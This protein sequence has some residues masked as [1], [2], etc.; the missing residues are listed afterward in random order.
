ML[1][2]PLQPS[3]SRQVRNDLVR[4]QN[5]IANSLVGRNVGLLVSA[6]RIA[7]G[8]VAAV[9][10]EAGRPKLVVAGA[11]YDLRQVLTASPPCV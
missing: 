7:R 3:S 2:S 10:V 5:G 4:I 11:C 8:I 6:D 1:Q 9:R